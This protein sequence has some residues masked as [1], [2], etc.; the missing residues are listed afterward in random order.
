MFKAQ[1][2]FVLYTVR[3]MQ[4]KFEVDSGEY[5]FTS[6]WFERQGTAMHYIDEG[7]GIPVVMCHGNPT[8]SYLYRNII[9]SLSPHFRCIAADYP[10]FG[11]SGH[12]SGYGYIIGG[13]A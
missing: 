11:Y 5:P 13:R 4:K 8:W 1:L 12:P 6:R 7:Q 9:K 3:P 10:G 2:Q